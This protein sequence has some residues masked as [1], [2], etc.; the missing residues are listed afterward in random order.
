MITDL[1][2]RAETAGSRLFS[3]EQIRTSPD[4]LG[5]FSNPLGHSLDFKQSYGN[6][7]W[8]VEPVAGSGRAWVETI[9]PIKKVFQVFSNETAINNFQINDRHEMILFTEFF[10][11]LSTP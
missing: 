7:R 3:Q 6:D 8:L 10:F 5:S 4:E 9:K 2:D 1:A 11:Q